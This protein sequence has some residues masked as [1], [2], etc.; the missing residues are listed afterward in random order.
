MGLVPV[1]VS[2]FELREEREIEGD[3]R[4]PDK[5]VELVEPPPGAA[6]H[7]E[8][9]LYPRDAGFDTGA[10]VAKLAIDP[11]ALDHVFDAG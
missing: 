4:R 6:R 7:A 5:S 3:A 11:S 9:A 8:T 10:E 1:Q 2:W